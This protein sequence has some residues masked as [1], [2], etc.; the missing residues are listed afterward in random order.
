MVEETKQCLR[1]GSCCRRTIID[2]IY[3][4]DLI[5]E[6]KLRKYVEPM[7]IDPNFWDGV[8]RY[9]LRTPCPFLIVNVGGINHNLCSIYHTR[10]TICVALEPGSKPACPQ[11]E[12]SKQQQGS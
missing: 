8:K 2:D 10:P 6:P 5:R 1:C 9:F 12:E 3:E 7:R 4:V 11:Y